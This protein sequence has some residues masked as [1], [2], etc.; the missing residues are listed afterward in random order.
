[1]I[2]VADRGVDGN[3]NNAVYVIDPAT[4]TPEPDQL[5]Q[6]PPPTAGDLGGDLTE[7]TTV[8]SNAVA[9]VSVDGTLTL[10]GPNGELN[11][12]HPSNLW[13]LG[14]PASGTAIAQDPLTGKIWAADDLKDEIWS[15]DSTTSE[16]QREI[17]FPL[18][19]LLRTDRQIDIH[20]P[21]WRAIRMS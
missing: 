2:V 19:E 14:G 17:G 1:M 7:I 13:P 15:I 16:D 8:G 9:T 3:A 10:I 5:R 20:D 21:G 11:Y 6:V 12:L 18:T 4:H